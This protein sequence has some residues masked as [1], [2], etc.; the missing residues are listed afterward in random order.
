MKLRTLVISILTCLTL[1]SGTRAQQYSWKIT[2]YASLDTLLYSFTAISCTGENCTAAGLVIG[3]RLTPVRIMFFRSSDGGLTWTEQDPGLPVE[4]STVQNSI[5]AIQQIDSLDVV[6]VGDSGLIVRTFDGGKTWIRQNLHTQHNFFDVHFSDAA[7]GIVIANLDTNVYVTS[8]S[9]KTWKGIVLPEGLWPI[10]GHSYGSGKFKVFTYNAGPFYST[11][12]WWNTVDT[13]YV[14]PDTDQYHNLYDCSFSPNG[15]TIVSVGNLAPNGDGFLVSWSTNAGAN[16]DTS[17]TTGLPFKAES[18][19]ITLNGGIIDGGRPSLLAHCADLNGT[20]QLDTVHL[21][22]TIIP[23]NA[24]FG[25]K[26][27][28]IATLPN[29]R[30]LAIYSQAVNLI[31][32][33]F[34]ILGEPATNSGVAITSPLSREM[35]LFPNPAADRINV[36]APSRVLTISDALGRSY[37]CPRTGSTL[38]VSSLPAGVYYVNAGTSRARFVKE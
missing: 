38:D 37:V 30:I 12:D 28:S 14:F 3:Q 23:K 24:W 32:P 29:G 20:W 6:A 11:S 18:I 13:S 17:K 22:T 36:E 5:S 16:W 35:S 31:A 34:L 8:D 19:P 7:T 15:D 27:S 2:H 25:Y 33:S 4:K 26:L 21:D 9:G 10:R 1:V